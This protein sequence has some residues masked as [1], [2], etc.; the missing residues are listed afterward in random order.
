MARHG[1]NIHKRKDGRWEGRYIKMYDSAGKAKYGSVYGKTY[2]EAKKRLVEITEQILK[3]VLPVKCHEITFREV[4]FLWLQNNRIKLK[5]QTYA[6]YLFLAESHLIPLIGSM[7]V[8][9]I[10][11]QYVNQL[12]EEKRKSGRL[13]G[14]GGLSSSYIQTI[15]F[16]IKAVLDYA[17]SEG[18]RP[19][20][21]GTIIK[22]NRKH[23]SLEV[24]S[25]AEQTTLLQYISGGEINDKKL[26]VLLSL[27]TGLRIGEVCGL[28]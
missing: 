15:G 14:K 16:I 7:Q 18:Y 11:S 26:G 10:G 4:L 22:P 9:K 5:E 23:K 12:L 3:N 27:Y 13:D 28:S 8:K 19:P 21:S 17:V 1:E 6:K 20:I 25:I 2:I 24:L